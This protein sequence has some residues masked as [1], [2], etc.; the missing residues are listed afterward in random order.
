MSDGSDVV[1]YRIA[2]QKHKQGSEAGQI[3]CAIIEVYSHYIVGGERYNTL[4]AWNAIA[5]LDKVVA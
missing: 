3:S 5:V 2:A 4:D 1:E